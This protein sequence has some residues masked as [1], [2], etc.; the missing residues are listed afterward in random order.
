MQVK[1]DPFYKCLFFLIIML[2]KYFSIDGIPQTFLF[3]PVCWHNRHHSSWPFWF[4]LI[5]FSIYA[6]NFD[7][8]CEINSFSIF[9]VNFIS[10]SQEVRGIFVF[11]SAVEMQNN[12][13]LKSIINCLKQ[14]CQDVV[15]LIDCIDKSKSTKFTG[16]NTFLCG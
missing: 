14:I 9:S 15:S 12:L 5:F 7:Y 8:C 4:N 1:K 3:F 16:L 6:I 10:W 11:K 13:Q 2:A